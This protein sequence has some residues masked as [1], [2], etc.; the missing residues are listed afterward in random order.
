MS[1]EVLCRSL[2]DSE[3]TMAMS[4]TDSL[5]I[6]LAA[7]DHVEESDGHWHKASAGA[8]AT[9]QKCDEHQGGWEKGH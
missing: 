7:L 4:V 6:L 9:L 1:M 3:D 5:R 8:V 2:L